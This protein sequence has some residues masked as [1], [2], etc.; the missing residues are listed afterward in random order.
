MRNLHININK[1]VIATTK[2]HMKQRIIFRMERKM[3][4]KSEKK[5]LKHSK[6]S[7]SFH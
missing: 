7:E 6:A 4:E 3:M 5:S 2:V 1:N